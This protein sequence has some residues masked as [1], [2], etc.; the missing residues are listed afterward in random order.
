MLEVQAKS[1]KRE[2]FYDLFEILR[3]HPEWR[4]ELASFLFK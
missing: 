4:E 2:S 1:L 3:R